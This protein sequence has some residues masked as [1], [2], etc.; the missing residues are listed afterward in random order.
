MSN[1]SSSKSA[2]A[3]PAG[4]PPSKISGNQA[5][6]LGIA[7]SFLFTLLIWVI[8]P[9]LP[10]IDFLPDTGYSWYY[11]KLPNPTWVTRTA[12]WSSYLAHQLFFWW[13]IYR[14]QRDGL[15][16]GAGL[17][18]LNIIALVGNALFITWHLVQ[19]GIW[20]DGLAQDVP[21]SSS[22]NSVI[23]MLVLILHM[24]NQR[25]GIF[26]GRKLSFLTETG[27]VLRKYHGYIFAW[28]IVYTFW[29]HPMENGTGHL[30]GF[31]YMFLLMVQGSLFFTRIHLNRYWTFLLEILVLIHGALVALLDQQ[32]ELW[33][34]FGFGFAGIFIVTQMH[35]L[36]L[37][38]WQRWAFFAIYIGSAL[39]VYSS[40]G[41]RTLADLHQLTWIP[42]TE[43]AVMF[44]I[45]GLI[46]V[47]MRVFGPAK[48]G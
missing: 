26:L 1:P 6:W 42:V 7:F 29:Y 28:A 46:W 2:T 34:M 20:Y 21:I 11:W 39:Y 16:Y 30:I 48:G 9:L 45:A 44:A 27:R 18:R 35:G 23:L 22:Q 37:K 24:E 14:A 15:K 33:S 31:F 12:A 4:P 47:G 25:R 41:S 40:L 32:T 17:H 5:L 36:G 10:Q 13:L 38:N 19:T 43:Y 8:R 3:T